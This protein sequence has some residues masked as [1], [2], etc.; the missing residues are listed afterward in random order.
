MIMIMSENKEIHAD[1][2]TVTLLFACLIHE[3]HAKT[4]IPTQDSVML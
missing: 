4:I 2:V 1:Y 3:S